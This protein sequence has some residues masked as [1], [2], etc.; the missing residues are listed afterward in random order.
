L[1]LLLLLLPVPAKLL[2]CPVHTTEHETAE[3]IGFSEELLIQQ[4]MSHYRMVPVAGHNAVCACR[5]QAEEPAASIHLDVMS[6]RGASC[7]PT[8]TN[9]NRRSVKKSS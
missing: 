2:L 5:L 3:T 8:L 7:R 1:L 6:V 4:Q 9:P